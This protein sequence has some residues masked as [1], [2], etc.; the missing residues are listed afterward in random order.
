MMK[1]NE[2]A[3]LDAGQT[4]TLNNFHD[5][6]SL[7]WSAKAGHIASLILHVMNS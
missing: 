2:I 5:A 4:A 3:E 1:D 7:V 6:L